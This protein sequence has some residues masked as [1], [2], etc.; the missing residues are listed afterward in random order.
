MSQQKSAA[1]S[2]FVN[3]GFEAVQQAFGTEIVLS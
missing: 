2:G 1:I 3:P